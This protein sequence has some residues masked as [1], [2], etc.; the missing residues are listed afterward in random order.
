M[1]TRTE[2]LNELLALSC[3]PD[4]AAEALAAFAWDSEELVQLGRRHVRNALRGFLAHEYSAPQL[5]RWAEVVEGR[6]DI[7]F[8][9]ADTTALKAVIFELA[10][11]ELEGALT[12]ERARKLLLRMA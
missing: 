8:E 3:A 11:P 12:A 4:D 1:R 2:W 6:D 10:S 7:G 9:P 5:V